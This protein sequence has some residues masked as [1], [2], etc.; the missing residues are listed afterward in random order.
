MRVKVDVF[1]QNLKK[2][3]KKVQSF[4]KHPPLSILPQGYVLLR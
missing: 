2:G 4:L 1:L 3:R